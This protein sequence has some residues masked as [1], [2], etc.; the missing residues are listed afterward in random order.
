[1]NTRTVRFFGVVGFQFLLLLAVIGFKQYAV[2]TGETV[3]LAVQPLDP[4]SL[5]RG[6]YVHFTYDISRLDLAALGGDDYFSSGAT[7]YTELVPGDDGLWHAVAVYHQH[8]P[9]PDGHLLLKGKVQSAPGFSAQD[10]SIRVTYGI[11]DVFVPEG[12]GRD[13]E[14]VRSGLSVEVT[15]DRFGNGIARRILVAGRPLGDS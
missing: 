12:S 3:R 14:A 5:F 10:Q 6:D 15:V 2:W 1:M 4:R 9:T 13:I 8:R 7:V 11:E